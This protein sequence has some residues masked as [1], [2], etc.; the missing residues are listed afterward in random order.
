[1][2]DRDESLANDDNAAPG[3]SG[4]E[5]T[6]DGDLT[7]MLDALRDDEPA[8]EQDAAVAPD[9]P[10]AQ[11]EPEVDA[12]P[13]T[14]A[15]LAT[16]TEPSTDAVSAAPVEPAQ[17]RKPGVFGRLFG[18]RARA[19]AGSEMI[20]D[21][22]A[23][24]AADDTGTADSFA[25]SL[26]PSASP[27]QVLWPGDLASPAGDE[28]ASS[29]AEAPATEDSP[30]YDNPWS[31]E[32][33]P[34]ADATGVMPPIVDVPR[35][36]DMGPAKRGRWWLVA[37]IVVL[38][39]AALGGVGYAWW[40]STSREIVA[41]DVVGKKP[42]EATQTLNDVGL[43]LG[44]VSEV[45]TDAAPVG[46]IIAQKPEAGSRLKPD[47]SLSFVVAAAPEQAKVPN[48]AGLSVEQAAAA[49]AEARLRPYEVASYN[50]SV[51]A[52]FVVAQLPDSGT[53]IIPGSAIAVVV[54]RGPAPVAA[55]VPRVTGMAE[56]DALTLLKA[57]GFQPR[58]YRSPDASMVA[59]IVGTQTPLAGVAATPGSVVQVA[60]SQGFVA[61]AVTVPDVAGRT[62][63]DAVDA[64]AA[65]KLKAEVVV[66]AN[67]TVAR[68]KVIAQMPQAGGASAPNGTVGILVSRGNMVEGPVPSLVGTASTEATKSITAA[69]FRPVLLTLPIQGA[70]AGTVFAQ[71]P[72]P[73]VRYAFRLPV[74]CLVAKA[75]G[76]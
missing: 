63:K 74:V 61:N 64:L 59:G 8:A 35:E 36:M 40:W 66:V 72:A 44:R 45:P 43:R 33:V 49:L 51:A 24:A 34:P 25:D 16:D 14:G 57:V 53:E 32:P 17:E 37:L 30:W 68:G 2:I 50:T 4:P 54:S 71:F 42:A 10:A 62:R 7:A 75:E 18:G 11:G 76:Q 15:E 19:K 48:V 46:T 1:M 41:P 39:L 12:E 73:G 65:K 67:P 29:A 60:V 26:P 23:D 31:A 52:G 47:D 70:Q 55:T 5:V 56:A 21:E 58:V 13:A 28:D 20:G 3:P 9:A 6:E 22:P 69:G 38:V 27:T